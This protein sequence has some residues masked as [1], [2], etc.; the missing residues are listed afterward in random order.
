HERPRLGEGAIGDDH[1]GRGAI[2]AGCIAGGDGS[3]FAESRSQPGQRFYRRIGP[4]GFIRDKRLNPPLTPDLHGHDFR[5]K[6]A[7]LLR[8]AETL[9]R[10]RGEAVLRLAGELRLHDEVFRMPSGMSARKGVVEAVAQHAVMNHRG[11]HA[12]APAPAI[13]QVRSTV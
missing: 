2:E 6:L 10:T 8:P 9:L 11:T 13:D 1:G 4:W 3:A 7:V 12:V 5:G